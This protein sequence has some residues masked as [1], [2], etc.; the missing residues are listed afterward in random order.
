MPKEAPQ[1]IFT[2]DKNNDLYNDNFDQFNE[3]E[4]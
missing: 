3:P 2:S 4:Y 1:I